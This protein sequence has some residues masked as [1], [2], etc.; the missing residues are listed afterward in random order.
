MRYALFGCGAVSVHLRRAAELAG[1]ELV[2]T[3]DP[4]DARDHARHYRDMNRALEDHCPDAAI[5][6]T[7]HHVSCGLTAELLR[8]GIHVY[9]EKPIARTTRQA[10]S[11]IDSKP[12]GVVLAVGE[13]G[14]AWGQVAEARAL[15]EG[16]RVLSAYGHYSEST[17]G[18][19]FRKS[20]WRADPQLAG[21]GVLIDGGLH[22]IR[23]LR[24]VLGGE[25]VHS[26]FASSGAYVQG[27]GGE[28]QVD[29][30]M[31]TETGRSAVLQCT[32]SPGPLLTD[33]AFL[34][35]VHDGGEVAVRVPAQ[36]VQAV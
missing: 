18:G 9:Q 23:A 15:T 21:G 17:C 2:C 3:V 12:D 24:H 32:L 7:P 10:R 6:A 22:W 1:A 26:V 4:R 35:V 20:D 25:R 19:P 34:R 29:A 28:S 36:V 5:V 14:A 16:R 8:R 27:F 13:N 11:L 33:Q 30:L 31:L